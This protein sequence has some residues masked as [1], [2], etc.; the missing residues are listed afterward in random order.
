[1][2]IFTDSYGLLKLFD[3]HARDIFGMPH[4]SGSCV[5]LE[6]HSCSNLTEYLKIFYKPDVIFELK[7]VKV[8]NVEYNKQLQNVNSKET[9]TGTYTTNTNI[10]MDCSSLPADISNHSS[11]LYTQECSI[12]LYAVAFST[13]LRCSYWTCQTEIAIIEHAIQMYSEGFNNECQQTLDHFPEYKYM[14]QEL[15]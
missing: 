6:F 14:A 5:L 1:M 9:V 2:S 11:I 10:N 15:I 4:P 3:S 13:I 7:G 8:S 12:Y